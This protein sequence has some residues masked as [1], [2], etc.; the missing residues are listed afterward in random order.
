M[1]FDVL[2]ELRDDRLDLVLA[3]VESRCGPQ[4]LRMN[5]VEEFAA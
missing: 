3:L 2:V 1:A 4:Y 5:R